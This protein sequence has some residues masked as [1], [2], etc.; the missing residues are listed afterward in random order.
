MTSRW[1]DSTA[2]NRADKV[3]TARSLNPR[4]GVSCPYCGNRNHRE[5]YGACY[6]CGGVYRVPASA[7]TCEEARAA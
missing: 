5:A 2:D 6:A 1:S 3:L 4:W 7:L